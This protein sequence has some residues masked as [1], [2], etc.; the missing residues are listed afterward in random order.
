MMQPTKPWYRYDFT[1][2]VVAFH[3]W[4]AGRSFF[5]QRKMGPVI[6]IVV[7]VVFHQPP[8]MVKGPEISI[9]FEDGSNFTACLATK[10][11]LE[12]KWIRCDGD[13]STVMRSDARSHKGHLVRSETP[14]LSPRNLAMLYQRL[15]DVHL[16]LGFQSL[17]RRKAEVVEDV[18]LGDVTDENRPV[19][20]LSFYDAYRE[21]RTDVRSMTRRLPP[22]FSNLLPEV[23]AIYCRAW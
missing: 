11:T 13:A 23:A 12:A 19:L 21:L 3:G 14:I 22:F 6:V 16:D 10:R 8:Q 5:G 7:D 17:R 15:P 2:R 20:S 4:P 1:I 9:D 18:S